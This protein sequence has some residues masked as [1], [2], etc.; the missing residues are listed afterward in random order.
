[1]NI[2]IR[3]NL[4]LD[5]YGYSGS[6]PD[7]KYGET[8]IKLSDRV[9]SFV[10]ENSLPNKGINVWVY[11]SQ[12]KMFCGLEL[13]PPP[14]NDFVMEHRV[15]H[16]KKYAWFKHVGPYRLLYETNAKARAEIQKMGLQYG[17][18]SLEIY[19]HHDVD[20]QKLETEIIYTLL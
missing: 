17:M 15:I 10:G 1:M 16:L 2:E 5:L 6:V 11:D 13:D 19:G 7:L 12:T 18:P 14:K 8:G 20:E 4:K 3:E 9:W